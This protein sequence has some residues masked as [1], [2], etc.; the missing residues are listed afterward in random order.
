MLAGHS[1]ARRWKRV[2][3]GMLAQVQAQMELVQG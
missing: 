1:Q 2:C 3:M